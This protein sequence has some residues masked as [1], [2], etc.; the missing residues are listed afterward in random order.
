MVIQ[1]NEGQVLFERVLKVEFNFKG[2]RGRGSGRV[3]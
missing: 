2:V 1:G 3:L